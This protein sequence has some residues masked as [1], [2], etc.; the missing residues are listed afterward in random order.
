MSLAWRVLE[1]NAEHLRRIVNCGGNGF[2]YIADQSDLD[3]FRQIVG[4]GKRYEFPYAIRI[5]HGMAKDHITKDELKELRMSYIATPLTAGGLR[6]NH[7]W[8]LCGAFD[9]HYDWTA[10]Q[11]QESWCLEED[12]NPYCTCKHCGKTFE[13]DE[14]IYQAFTKSETGIGYGLVSICRDCAYGMSDKVTDYDLNEKGE[15]LL[16]EYHKGDDGRFRRLYAAYGSNID[17]EQMLF[18]CPNAKMSVGGVIVDYELQ[19]KHHATIAPKAH[20]LAPVLLWELTEED[21][22]SLDK[23]EHCPEGY[24]RKEVVTVSTENGEVDALVYV[25]NGDKPLARPSDEYKVRITRGYNAADFNTEFLDAALAAA[26]AT[27]IVVTDVEGYIASITK[28]EG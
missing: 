22:A 10:Q 26:E 19:F 21:E 5:G 12:K 13:D 3:V 27:G 28:K 7:S 8:R 23:F 24:Y 14:I 25:M 2:V 17:T 9:K 16:K 1:K 20:S 6:D 4:D 18:R 11:W 15:P